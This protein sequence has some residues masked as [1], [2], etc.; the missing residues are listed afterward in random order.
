MFEK[1]FDLSLLTSAIIHLLLAVI[2]YFIVLP[3]SPIKISTPSP[4]IPIEL[5]KE[6]EKEE[7]KE[8]IE[9]KEPRKVIIADKRLKK[10]PPPPKLITKTKIKEIKEKS[11]AKKPQKIT[12][13]LT[14]PLLKEKIAVVTKAPEKLLSVPASTE[15]EK[16]I[17]A[18]E[19]T[20]PLP[21]LVSADQKASDIDLPLPKDTMQP[22][23]VATTP[24]KIAETGEVTS[25]GVGKEGEGKTTVTISGPIVI[26]R[27]TTY[28]PKFELPE[29][30]E[31]R[32]LRPGD[33]KIKIWVTADGKVDE[34]RLVISSGYFKLDELAIETVKKWRFEGIEDI[35]TRDWGIVNIRIKFK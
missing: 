1:E 12:E 16:K 29:W 15:T 5:I 17:L 35:T 4:I 22:T 26:L 7:P 9:K 11:K 6:I 2:A 33:V 34:T 19:T 21:K 8:K 20:A 32:G 30:I 25:I 28:K 24:A 31:K 10:I 14:P 27:K 3:A 18:K 13:L 23:A